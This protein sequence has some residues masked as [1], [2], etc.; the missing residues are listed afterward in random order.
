MDEEERM[1]VRNPIQRA[2]K[3]HLYLYYEILEKIYSIF[4]KNEK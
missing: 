2:K 4:K 3:Q 1:R